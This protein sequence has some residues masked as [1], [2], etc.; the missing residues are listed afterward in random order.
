MDFSA[1]QRAA[2]AEEYADTMVSL[3]RNWDALSPEAQA[4]QRREF[5]R[6]ASDYLQGCEIHF[7]RSAKRIQQNGALVPPEKRDR[8]A[9][10][11]REMLDPLC[12]EAEF[13]RAVTTL[14]AEFPLIHNWLSWWLQPLVARML[15]PVKKTMSEEDAKHLPRTSNPVETQHSLLHHASGKGHDLISGIRGLFLHCQE[16]ERHHKAILGEQ[17]VIEVLYTL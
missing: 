16:L 2:H 9:Q 13:D 12:V 3:F 11:L 6:E 17:Y 7:W 14:C 5:V 8:F 15:F 10:L 1:A 4:V